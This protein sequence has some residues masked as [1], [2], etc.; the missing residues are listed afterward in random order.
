MHSISRRLFIGT[1]FLLLLFALANAT[2]VILN[3]QDYSDVIAGAVYAVSNDY[4][5]VFA[6]TPNQ[7][8]F[9]SQYYTLNP[10][11]PIIYVEGH[12]P[13]LANMASLIRESGV[14]NLTVAQPPD[15]EAWIA[16]RMPREQAI[17]VG[18]PYGQDALSVSSYASLTSSP[19]FFVDDPSDSAALMANLSAMG[20]HS[21]LFYGPVAHQLPSNQ[22]LLFPNRRTIDLGSKYLNNLKIASEFLAIQPATQAMF[23]SG[24]TFEKSMADKN[25]PLL[26]A[27]RSDVPIEVPDFISQNGIRSGVVFA[28]D[29]DIV[30]GLN[31]LRTVSPNLSLFVKFGEGYL[32]GGQSSQPMPLMVIPL[33]APQIAIEVINLSYNVPSKSFEVRLASRGDFASIRS[34]ITV[35]SVGAAES[36]QISLDP[37]ATTTLAIPLDAL[38]ASDGRFIGQAMLTVRY[39]EDSRLLE[40]VDTISFVDVPISYYNDTSFVRVLNITYSDADKSFVIVLDGQGWVEGQIQFTI[41]NQPITLRLP[42]TQVNGRTSVSVKYLLSPDEEKFVNGL[43]ADYFIRS[44]DRPDILIKETRGQ[45]VVL[46]PS[47]TQNSEGPF[48]NV[49]WA[50]ICFFSFAIVAV[51]LLLRH[52]VQRQSDSF[53]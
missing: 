21:V 16:G 44:G 7:S 20:Y 10:A 17:V 52:F 53:D 8:V 49:P 31:R 13:V 29:S 2:T 45:N 22:L 47:L 50:T 11:E 27:G 35:P 5:Y 37:N 43:P 33:P 28:G 24:R 51:L 26:L 42:S 12:K 48:A 34:S 3:S 38:R 41:N 14:H 15:V 23:V 40:N 1:V 4:Q 18:R 39:G 30:D 19:L 9:I 25:F 36:S 32:Y 46:V 6:L